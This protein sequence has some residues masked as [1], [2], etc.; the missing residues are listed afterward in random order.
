MGLSQHQYARSRKERGM[1]GGSQA[2]VSKAVA[3][4]RI[5]ALP[6]GTIDPESA[7][8]EWEANTSEALRRQNPVEAQHSGPEPGAAAAVTAEPAGQA[9][10]PLDREDSKSEIE[11]QVLREK[12]I[13]LR[14]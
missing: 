11:K 7:D 3:A 5:H 12:Q 14:R 2:A 10:L 9:E 13:K 6:D 4:G 1:I 8:R